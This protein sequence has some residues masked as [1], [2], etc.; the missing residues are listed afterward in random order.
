MH[1]ISQGESKKLTRLAGCRIKRTRSIFEIEMLIY[2][3]K[4]NKDMKIL[5]GK[6]AHHLYTERKKTEDTR[7][8]CLLYI[9]FEVEQLYDNAINKCLTRTKYR[10]FRSNI[11]K[12][13][14]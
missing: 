8:K 10:N 14:S 5:L 11:I 7:N 13:L 9:C 1:Q 12:K 6:I 2:Q 3:S 4:A